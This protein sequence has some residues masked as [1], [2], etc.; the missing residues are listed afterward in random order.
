MSGSFLVRSPR[1]SGLLPWAVEGA[2][3]E[4]PHPPIF[5]Q[6]AGRVE[7][8]KRA[9]FGVRIQSLTS[10]GTLLIIKVKLKRLS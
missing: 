10:G 3:R 8:V 5:P 6:E 4:L 2:P 9:A 7:G 1:V